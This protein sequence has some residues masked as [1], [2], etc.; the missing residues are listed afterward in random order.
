MKA[1]IS[2]AALTAFLLAA[3]LGL[4]SC[5]ANQS[6]TIP[7]PEAVEG[8]PRCSECHD[9][10]LAAV[11]HDRGYI[12]RHPAYAAQRS[13]VC[14]GCHGP[15]FC[16]DCHGNKEELKPSDKY[17]D[18][19]GRMMPHRGDYLTQHRIDGRVNPASCFKCHGRKNDWRCKSC[20]R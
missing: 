14:A 7:H 3:I 6:L 4:A 18:A 2:R 9:N 12:E 15:S 17:R 1:T 19:P 11:D 13:A 5:A 8:L 16:A 10:E 20:H